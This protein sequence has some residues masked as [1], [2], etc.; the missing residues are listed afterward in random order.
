MHPKDA[1]RMAHDVDPDLTASLE[2]AVWSGTPL[3]AQSYQSKT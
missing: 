2:G 1:Y 3:L